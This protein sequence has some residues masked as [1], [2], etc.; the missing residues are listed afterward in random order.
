[1]SWRD[2]ASCSSVERAAREPMPGTD[3][4]EKGR[5]PLLGAEVTG[6]AGHAEH[7]P[8][9]YAHELDLQ[10]RNLACQLADGAIGQM[11]D[12]AFHQ[13]NGVRE[14]LLREDRID[15]DDLAHE[16]EIEYVLPAV[17]IHGT[18]LEAAGTHGIQR[19]K[20][21]A[22]AKQ[23]FARCQGGEV[24]NHVLELA[25]R[26]QVP[27]RRAGSAVAGCRFRNAAAPD[28]T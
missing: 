25:Q 27:G 23:V 14:M 18:G 4:D 3:H 10:F 7:M 20:A 13:R 16:V 5:E 24:L 11:T 12:R 15:A 2:I 9:Q 26:L 8:A 19:M 17:G 21:V 1:M 6:D 22:D 28:P